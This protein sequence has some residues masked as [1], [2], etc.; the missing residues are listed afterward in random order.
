VTTLSVEDI[1]HLFDARLMMEL[2]GAERA[3]N[4]PG[5][6]DLGELGT[7]LKRSKNLL[8]SGRQFDYSA[9]NECDSQLHL[10]LVEAAHNPQ[11]TRMYL[12]LHGHMQIMRVYWGRARKRALKSQREH[13]LIYEAFQRGNV[14][15]VQRALTAHLTSS[16]DD[17][18]LL[19]KKK[20]SSQDAGASG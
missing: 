2:W 12:A 11:L 5:A 13:L 9:F 19:L 20:R 4:C 18:L 1:Q 6:L 15:G 8:A 14:T 10:R 7:L 16:R 3:L 17:V